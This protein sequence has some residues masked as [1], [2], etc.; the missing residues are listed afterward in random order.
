M[1]KSILGLLS[2]TTLLWLSWGIRAQQPTQTVITGGTLIDG[3]GGSPVRDAAIVVEGN[4]IQAVGPRSSVKYR[5]GARLIDASGKFVLPGLIDSHIHYSHWVPQIYLHMG[6]TSIVDLGND[7]EWIL[8]TKELTAQGKVYGPRI[9][10]AA[11]PFLSSPPWAGH[12]KV[13]GEDELFLKSPEHA[14]KAVRGLVAMGVD[15]I[16]IYTNLPPERIQAAAEEAHNAG[17][18]V[19]A[20]HNLTINAREAVFLG[21]DCI[22]HGTG[23]AVTTIRDARAFREFVNA[24]FLPASYAAAE[25]WYLTTPADYDEPVRF[26]VQRKVAI[27]PTSVPIW[28]GVLDRRAAIAQEIAR[29]FAD[30][31]LK[32]MPRARV[33]AK[34][35]YSRWDKMP[36]EQLSKIREG[37]GRYKQFLKKFSD[38][39]GVILPGSDPT[40]SGLP[41]LGVH[42]EMEALVDAGLS[43]MRVIV[44]ATKDSADFIHKAGK[45]GVG[46]I[47]SGKLADIIIVRDDPLVNITNIRNSVEQVMQDGKFVNI[48]YT[49]DFTS[50]FPKGG[51]WETWEFGGDLHYVEDDTGSHKADRPFPASLLP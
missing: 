19:F 21:V 44:A 32:Y 11:G 4:R 34:L 30:P 50:A 48:A 41:G 7:I 1:R 31:G 18:P 23:L 2:L 28:Q 42:H 39:G 3:R 49:P 24:G 27:Q 20:D 6:V 29:V 26:L 37:Y 43:P 13:H 9:L 35:D 33:D 12:A 36:P 17:I 16:K 38:A 5:P 15:A 46:T 47:E 10:G 45:D 14:R 51:K 40:N 22:V 8:K 25:P